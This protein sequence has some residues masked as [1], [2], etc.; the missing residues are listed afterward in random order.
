LL[1]VKGLGAASVSGLILPEGGTKRADF[2][3]SVF[4]L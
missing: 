4:W 3:G 1:A 2:E